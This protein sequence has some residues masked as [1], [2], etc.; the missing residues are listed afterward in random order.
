MPTPRSQIVT[1]TP[2]T[3]TKKRKPG[4]DAAAAAASA[5]RLR[6]R[7]QWRPALLRLLRRWRPSNLAL[8]MGDDRRDPD[9]MTWC[10]D[11]VARPVPVPP[12]R[13]VLR[14][15]RE[16]HFAYA[17]FGPGDLDAWVQALQVRRRGGCRAEP[18]RDAD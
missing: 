16:V 3:A 18:C 11:C 8:V 6:R 15:A 2:P 13:D 1:F 5:E 4:A 17:V 12:P 14:L 10:D 7:R 9:T